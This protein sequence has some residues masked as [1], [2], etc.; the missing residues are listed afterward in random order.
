MTLLQCLFAQQIF[1]YLGLNKYYFLWI[2]IL[3]NVLHLYNYNKCS[4]LIQTLIHD[5]FAHF[6][7]I[8]SILDI[9]GFSIW[10]LKFMNSGV[11]TFYDFSLCSADHPWGSHGFQFLLFHLFQKNSQYIFTC[12]H[13]YYYS[14]NIICSSVNKC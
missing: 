14:L 9:R 13:N 12:F 4:F 3:Y 1:L 7:F 8:S 5:E 6:T 11:W 10:S 2:C